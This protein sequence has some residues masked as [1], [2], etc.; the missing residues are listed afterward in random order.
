VHISNRARVPF[1]W[2]LIRPNVIMPAS[3]VAWPQQLQASVLHHEFAH[4]RRGDHISS[5]VAQLV[6]VLHWFNPLAWFAASRIALESERACDHAVLQAGVRPTDYARQL[7]S[8]ASRIGP[9]FSS[10][11]NLA[12]ARTTQVENRI[13]VILAPASARNSRTVRFLVTAVLIALIV[14]AATLETF[15]RPAAQDP[16]ELHGVAPGEYAAGKL[17][18]MGSSDLNAI[19][20]AIRNED[21]NARKA[22]DGPRV[23]DSGAVEPLL[24]ALNDPSP[25]VRRIAAWGLGEI[26][27]PSAVDPLRALLEDDNKD[28]RAQA[29]QSLGDIANRKA[30]NNLI[31]SLSDPN[32]EV[33]LRSAH[34]LGDIQD[35]RAA[36]ALTKALEDEDPAVREKAAWAL[37]EIASPSS[38]GALIARAGDEDEDIDI[39]CRAIRGLG[40]IGDPEPVPFLISLLSHDEWRIRSQAADALGDIGAPESRDALENAANDTNG[41][42]RDN[43][44]KALRKVQ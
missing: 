32:A 41:H 19:A 17:E 40:E 8:V 23:V 25:I 21:W 43:A 5:L 13:R 26:G 3:A 18:E 24:V 27:D 12:F 33:R 15:A 11:G 6:C 44:R 39:R 14:P 4:I 2:G 30:T 1:V 10:D 31:E 16:V 42:V 38:I 20:K 28:V 37:V 22:N 9:R 29:A 35:E 36:P 7:L 34:A